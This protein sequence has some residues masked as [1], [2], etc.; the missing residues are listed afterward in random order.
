MFTWRVT[1]LL[2]GTGYSSS[3]TLVTDGSTRVLIDT[4][5]MLQE[6]ALLDALDDHGVR[7]GDIDL[8]INTH[9]HI[10]HCGNNA[11]FPRAAIV[12][13]RAEWQWT[14]AFYTALFT[15]R[16]PEV[17]TAQFYP[18]LAAHHV[19]TRT[20]RNVARLARMF[21]RRERLGDESR[22]RWAEEAELPAGLELIET[23]G[24]TPH[25]LSI[26]VHAAIPVVVAGDAVLAE[27]P[28]ARVRTMIPHSQ[29]LFDATRR[30][31]L[32]LGIRIIPGH[33]R[34]FE[35]PP[36]SRG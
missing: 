35:P 14:D 22:F 36:A 25:H 17:V 15:A 30:R 21:W 3:C 10:D 32:D 4:G 13:S 6:S 33:G 7:P 11:L 9:L 28:T 34:G 23:P 18:E 29:V 1:P 12:M 26:R 5:L 31:V 16:A 24:H 20:I 27:D 2:E 19:K 8:V